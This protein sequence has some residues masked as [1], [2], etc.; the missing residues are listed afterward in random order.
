VDGSG[1][2]ML[3]REEI[4]E[5]GVL[6]P[7]GGFM[8]AA[9]KERFSIPNG[10]AGR[11]EGKSSIARLGLF[12][13][14]TA[15][16]FDPGFEGYATLELFNAAPH[17]IRLRAGMPIAQMSFTRMSGLSAQPYGSTGRGSHY[18]GQGPDPT[19]SRLSQEGS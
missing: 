5:M 3:D 15:G 14:I 19:E 4:P 2:S 1:P 10:I 16:Y 11:L 13:H 6:L 12:I 17:P 8:L 9:T 18:Q 7:S